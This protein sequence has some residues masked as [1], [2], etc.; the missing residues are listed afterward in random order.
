MSKR[1]DAHTIVDIYTE[2][3]V[4]NDIARVEVLI[5]QEA[6]GGLVPLGRFFDLMIICAGRHLA[7]GDVA[8]ARRMLGVGVDCAGAL[9]AG[10][11]GGADVVFTLEGKELR[12]PG[13]PPNHNANVS[14]W[15]NAFCLAAA[16]RRRDVLQILSRHSQEQLR[17]APAGAGDRYRFPLAEGIRLFVAGDTAWRGALE[18]AEWLSRPE[19]LTVAP[20]IIVAR[21]RSLIPILF[22]IDALDQEAFSRACA[23]AVKAHKAY[24]ARGKNAHSPSGLIAYQAAGI[25]ALGVD[26]GLAYE[27]DSGYTPG[28]LMKV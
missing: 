23:D 12:G 9:F 1:I 22:A 10:A 8:T 11:G 13:G 14:M 28:W 20:P 17:A 15:L 19:N 16:L 3:D 4:A 6:A 25:S 26:R 5:P 21:Y 27:I 2:H 18:E 7:R 24:F